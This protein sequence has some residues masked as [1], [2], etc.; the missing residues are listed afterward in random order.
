MIARLK[1]T[2]T[3]ST[4]LDSKRSDRNKNCMKKRS[5]CLVVPTEMLSSIRLKIHRPAFQLDQMTL[6][7]KVNKMVSPSEIVWNHLPLKTSAVTVATILKILTKASRWNRSRRKDLNLN[8]LL[9]IR[10][11]AMRGKVTLVLSMVTHSLCNITLDILTHQSP[12]ISKR[13]RRIRN[14]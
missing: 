9:A 11:A 6:D 14:L 4:I 8:Q 13:Q 7:L 5:I 10:R 12:E 2:T 3:Q 1:T